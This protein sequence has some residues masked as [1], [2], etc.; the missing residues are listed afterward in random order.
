MN[1]NLL[2]LHRERGDYEQ[3][4]SALR[5]AVDVSATEAPGAHPYYRLLLATVLSDL[6][7]VDEVEELC[8]ALEAEAAR[9]PPFWRVSDTVETLRVR[10]RWFHGEVTAEDLERVAELA[11][12]V[13]GL[14]P[15]RCW[16]RSLRARWRWRLGRSIGR[17]RW[18]MPISLR[19]ID[20]RRVW[21]ERTH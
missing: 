9:L 21:G 7:P 6:G 4:I 2:M 1:A 12:D 14:V 15:A 11:S 20:R 10:L 5:A 18:R 3:A 8:A 16:H 17:S 19:P 13:V